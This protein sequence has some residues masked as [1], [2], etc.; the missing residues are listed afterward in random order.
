MLGGL[1]A[2]ALALFAKDSAT[3]H[4]L[5]LDDAWIHQVVARTFA[6]TG[7]L[8]YTAGEHGASATSYLWATLLAVNFAVLHA[9]PCLYT[10][11]LNVALA[12]VSSQLVYTMLSR[13]LGD[14]APWW[15]RLAVAWC[16]FAGGNVLWFSY[17]GMEATLSVTLALASIVTFSDPKQ[18]P[19]GAWLAGAF[20][21]AL[22]LTRPEAMCFP[23][24]L[25]IFHRSRPRAQLPFV[26]APWLIAI[27]LYFGSNALLAHTP[28]PATLSGRKWLWESGTAGMSR[29][30]LVLGF[31]E[32]WLFRLRNFELG[33]SSDPAFYASLGLV[34][35][36]AR[37]WWRR[38]GA[39][40]K[41]VLVWAAIH[42]CVYAALMPSP[43]HG[44]RYQPLVPILYSGLLALGS[45]SL[46]KELAGLLGRLRFALPVAS[47]ALL[48]PWVG[49]TT[50]GVI[51]WR[52]DHAHAVQHIRETEERMGEFVDTLSPEVK[53]ASFDIGAIGFR[54]HRPI[55][56]AGG[57][58]DAQVAA[59]LRQGKLVEVL[60]DRDIGVIVLPLADDINLP[61]PAN[62]AE[63]LN[64]ARNPAI[65]LLPLHDLSTPT[66]VWFSGFAATWNSSRHQGMFSIR[67][68][69][70]PGP[71]YSSTPFADAPGAIDPEGLLSFWSRGQVRRDL[72]ALAG[73]GVNVTLR[74]AH[75]PGAFSCAD[76]TWCVD[77]GARPPT[78]AVPKSSGVDVAIAKD[79]LNAFVK[80]YVDVG[81]YGGAGQM[82]AHMIA[83]WVTRFDRPSSAIRLPG[84]SGPIPGG[85][86]SAVLSVLGWA[87]PLAFVVFALAMLAERRARKL[88]R[89]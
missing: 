81:D 67:Y 42:F 40:M 52:D 49:L 80:P 18:T 4:G 26:V 38:G 12:L 50:V 37:T 72:G 55:M 47:A 7:T 11:V 9:D 54:A 13:E 16:A 35:F 20:A 39:G 6:T 71:T 46:A 79:D 1:H 69:D 86:R 82:T 2:A 33:T 34:A 88:A 59:A 60:R 48:G 30:E 68:T 76:E 14:A 61:D 23:I 8:G 3:L 62:F 78:L 53:V 85:H 45:L 58:S 83:R 31:V 66:K 41:M 63:R 65:E 21:G 29:A 89:A 57:L 44:G 5:P 64:L 24:V 56:D 70:E 87:A 73:A 25:A 36:G 22:A 75:S 74:V 27:T 77:L 10:L 17:S 84:V 32:T 15:S 28:L 43:G 19:R 51:D